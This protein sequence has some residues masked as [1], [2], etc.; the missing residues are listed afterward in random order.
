[1]LVGA[2]KAKSMNVGVV[3]LS[4][5]SSKNPLCQLGDVNLWVDSDQYNIV[6]MTHHVWLLAIVDYIIE[7]S[8]EK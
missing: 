4:G 6:E 5:F 7:I 8:K 1:M 3:T 2:N